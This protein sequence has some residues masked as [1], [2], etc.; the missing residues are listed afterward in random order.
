MLCFRQ[1]LSPSKQVQ[2]IQQPQKAT[3]WDKARLAVEQLADRTGRGIDT[4]IKETVAALMARGFPTVQSCEGH[5]SWGLPYPWVEIRTSEPDGW[6]DDQ[7]KE[8]QWRHR[9][10]TQQQKMLKLLSEFYRHRRAPFDAQL[11]LSSMGF[12]AF[13]VHSTG[14]EIVTLLSPEARKVKLV[15]YQH[16]MS[17]FTSFLKKDQFISA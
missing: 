7:K 4:G 11:C 12:G 15:L 10:L 9:N 14:A 5:L 3:A 6:R 2:H 8:A 1:L 16:E 17:D 13:R